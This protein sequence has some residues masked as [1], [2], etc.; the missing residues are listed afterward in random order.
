MD[1]M[2]NFENERKKICSKSKI[3]R[4]EMIKLK[5]NRKHTTM[6]QSSG[7]LNGKLSFYVLILVFFCCC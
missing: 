5:E 6:K 3:K 7:K 4:E 2:V 1:K